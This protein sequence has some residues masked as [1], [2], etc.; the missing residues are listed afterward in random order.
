MPTTKI[1]YA[2]EY[3]AVNID[4]DK[5]R[6]FQKYFQFF[7]DTGAEINMTGYS[8]TAELRLAED[9]GSTLIETFTVDDTDIAT[10]EI[11]I[12]LTS[13]QTAAISQSRG[14][15][16]IKITD[17]AGFIS[18]WVKGKAEIHGTVTA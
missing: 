5:G 4:I 6:D 3:A 1:E 16:D 10:G 17:S 13:V 9:Y 12:K 15:Y 14:Y 2:Q 7:D 11:Y 18:S 8:I